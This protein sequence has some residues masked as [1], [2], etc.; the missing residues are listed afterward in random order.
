[1]FPKIVVSPNHHIR[2]FHDY[3]LSILGY[4]YFWKHPCSG[5]NDPRLTRNPKCWH[6][7]LLVAL[8]Q[9]TLERLHLNGWGVRWFNHPL[10][11]NTKSSLRVWKFLFVLVVTWILDIDFCCWSCCEF[12]SL[13]LF[14]A[15]VCFKQKHWTNKNIA[16]NCNSTDVHEQ[17]SQ[18]LTAD[19]NPYRSIYP[20]WTTGAPCWQSQSQRSPSPSVVEKKRLKLLMLRLSVDFLGGSSKCSSKGAPKELQ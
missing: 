13:S 15:F 11:K 6:V 8:R 4:P 16:S 18:N 2:V 17:L 3:K 5:P 7:A 9:R 20:W 1:M 19:T 14:H 12:L 10:V